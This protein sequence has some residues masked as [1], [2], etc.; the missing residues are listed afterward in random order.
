MDLAIA[1]CCLEREFNKYL[2]SMAMSS[3]T[4]PLRMLLTVD[5][6]ILS[7]SIASP[8]DSISVAPLKG[9]GRFDLCKD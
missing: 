1:L 3:L 4:F 5:L 2:E 9:T 7:S 6:I 8:T